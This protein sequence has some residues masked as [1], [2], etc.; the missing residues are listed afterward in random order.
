MSPLTDYVLQ[1]T[2]MVRSGEE[3]PLCQANGVD[4]VL[5]F[6]AVVGE[7]DTAATL[8]RLVTEHKGEFADLIPF[9]GEEHSYIELGAWIGDQGLALRL[10]A[11][12][13]KVGLWTLLTPI[14]LLGKAISRAD[15]VRMA[16]NGLVAITTAVQRC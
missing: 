2:V 9:D 12:G 15:A 10:M 4:M 11:L 1:H 7:P 3:G 8:R 16:G 6:V 5:C 13:A 14:T